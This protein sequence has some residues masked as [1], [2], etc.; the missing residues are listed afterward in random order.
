MFPTNER[1]DDQD[2]DGRGKYLVDGGS[3]L[4]CHVLLSYGWRIPS[5]G[6]ED[7]QCRLHGCAPRY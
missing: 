1:T 3:N 5:F 2:M 7:R 6:P 4:F